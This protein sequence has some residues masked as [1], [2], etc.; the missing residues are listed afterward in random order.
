MDV[1]ICTWN[2]LVADIC[3]KGIEE[4]IPIGAQECLHG[5]ILITSS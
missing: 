1:E 4:E 5:A 2:L 3:E